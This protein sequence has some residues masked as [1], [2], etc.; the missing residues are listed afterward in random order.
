MANTTKLITDL[1][2]KRHVRGVRPTILFRVEPGRG[3]TGMTRVER[4]K[5]VTRREARVLELR[6]EPGRVEEL[7]VEE[8]DGRFCAI[9][10]AHGACRRI[11]DVPK[12]G[13]V[14]V[15]VREVDVWH[16][17]GLSVST[18]FCSVVL[19]QEEGVKHRRC[20]FV[21]R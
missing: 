13:V 15:R 21:G 12:R 5:I 3:L 19:D 4:D 8:E 6:G 11:G 18:R 16:L 14:V 1:E 10:A 20:A 9:E 17:P 7:R 2:R